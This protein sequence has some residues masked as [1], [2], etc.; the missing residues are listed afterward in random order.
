MGIRNQYRACQK[1][2]KFVYCFSNFISLFW[3][4]SLKWFQG[5]IEAYILVLGSKMPP[6]N[7]STPIKPSEYSTMTH[8]F[9]EVQHD[10]SKIQEWAPNFALAKSNK[11]WNGYFE[12]R[13]GS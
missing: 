13:R 1:K 5:N 8:E 12:E 7:N 6:K 4:I 2:E 3:K 10:I 9:E 11:K